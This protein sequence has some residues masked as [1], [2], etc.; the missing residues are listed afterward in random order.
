MPVFKYD[1]IKLRKISMDGADK[2][3]G[4]NL[5]GSEQGWDGNILR[6]FKS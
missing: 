5:I 1:E 2:V 4:V 3:T 6:V